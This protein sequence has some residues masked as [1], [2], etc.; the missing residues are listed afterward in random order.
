MD[1]ATPS[2]GKLT[3]ELFDECAAWVWEQLQEDGIML[4][5][6]LVDL[7]LAT[8]RELAIHTRP[9]EEIAQLLEEEFKMRGIGGNP[10]PIAAPLILQVLQW[11]DDFLGFAGISREES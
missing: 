11:E 3:G 1:S 2:S 7:I 10:Y 5:G 4:A 8:E 6:E 9:L